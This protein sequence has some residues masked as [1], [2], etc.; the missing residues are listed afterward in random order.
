MMNEN[1]VPVGK[2]TENSQEKA[3]RFLV[4]LGGIYY[5]KRLA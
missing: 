4:P 1:E 5:W 3:V 2:G